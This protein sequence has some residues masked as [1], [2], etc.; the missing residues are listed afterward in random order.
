MPKVTVNRGGGYDYTPLG[1][2]LVGGENTV[3]DDE[4]A[5]LLANEQIVREIAHGVMTIEQTR[6]E[7]A[8][9]VEAPQVEKPVEKPQPKKGK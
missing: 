5:I 6:T 1:R 4:L 3:T 9:E 7:P 8:G 2:V